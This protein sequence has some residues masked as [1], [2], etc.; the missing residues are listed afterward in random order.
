MAGGLSVPA[1]DRLLAD[2]LVHAR[3]RMPRTESFFYHL[4]GDR[5]RVIAVAVVEGECVVEDFPTLG[6][7][8]TLEWQQNSQN[9]AMTDVE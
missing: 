6:R 3:L 1:R 5:D 2:R 9:F 4:I 7:T 8:V